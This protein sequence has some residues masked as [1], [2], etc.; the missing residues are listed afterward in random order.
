MLLR[1]L[2][3][4]V[5]FR[6]CGHCQEYSYD[7]DTGAVRRFHGEDLRRDPAEKPPCRTVAGCPKGTP[8]NPRSLT[9]RNW[10]CYKHY[11]RCHAISRFPDDTL[12]AEH[13]VIIQ[14]A[15]REAWEQKQLDTMRSMLPSPTANQP[16]GGRRN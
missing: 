1:L 5:A 12:V 13:A 16:F 11:Q 8:E 10:L 14:E 4:E 3:P 7:E 9:P 15:E 6:D 2:H